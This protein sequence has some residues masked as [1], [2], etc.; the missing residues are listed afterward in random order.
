MVILFH[1]GF[2]KVRMA[3]IRKVF[4]HCPPTH[5]LV[6]LSCSSYY[7]GVP[8]V[9]FY[10]SHSFYIYLLESF[11][12]RMIFPFS[13][14]SIIHIIID[15]WIFYSLVYNPLLSLFIVHIV[16][17]LWPLGAKIPNETF[18]VSLCVL[19]TFLFYFFKHRTIFF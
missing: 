8:I 11:C 18:Q 14:Y 2:H 15:S 1:P 12:K 5:L 17:Q 13:I 7:C 3:D 9:G 4:T 16:F 10:F 6:N 19:L